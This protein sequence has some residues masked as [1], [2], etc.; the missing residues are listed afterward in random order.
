MTVTKITTNDFLSK[1]ESSD[2]V[3][4]YEYYDG[5][6]ISFGNSNCRYLIEIETDKYASHQYEIFEMVKDLEGL[7]EFGYTSRFKSELYYDSLFV[8]E[9][10]KSLH[11]S[12]MKNIGDVK[13]LGNIMNL[14]IDDFNVKWLNL[15]P[16][17]LKIIEISSLYVENEEEYNMIIEYF[18]EHNIDYYFDDYSNWIPEN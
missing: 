14:C 4:I 12:H 10:L 3:L 18:N 2:I 13:Q 8:N 17:T 5:L 16:K 9:N 7:K 6:Q 11:L 15:L 1:M